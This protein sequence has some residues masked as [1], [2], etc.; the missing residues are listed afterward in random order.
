MDEHDAMRGGRNQRRTL[1]RQPTTC[2]Y[3]AAYSIMGDEPP[4]ERTVQPWSRTGTRAGVAEVGLAIV[5]L[6]DV[7]GGYYAVPS[8]TLKCPSDFSRTE[9]SNSIGGSMA[10][11]R[12]G[13]L[14]TTVSALLM[15]PYGLIEIGL[16]VKPRRLGLG[17]PQ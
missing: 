11:C 8:E 10:A 6:D 15:S 3:E 7:G 2:E 13:N 9:V 17:L 16:S 14:T 12:H 1:R 5:T 4:E